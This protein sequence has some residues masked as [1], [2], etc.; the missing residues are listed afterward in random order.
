VPGWVAFAILLPI[1][2]FFLPFLLLLPRMAKRTG[3]YLSVIACI[4]LFG[5]WIDLNYLIMP[6][7]S[8]D[9]FHVGWQDIGLYIG[10]LGFFLFFVR[11][12]LAKHSL[13]PAKDPYL[14]ESLHHHVM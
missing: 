4:V 1:L 10:F 14:H 5:E 7:F 6:T 12:F 11:R 2:R 3:S 9:G 8:P 13:V